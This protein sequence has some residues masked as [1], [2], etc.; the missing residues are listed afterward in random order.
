MNLIKKPWFLPIVLTILIV[1]IGNYY[2][3]QFI[4]QAETLPEDKVRTQLEGMYDGKV[5]RLS[6]KGSM[7]E[8][9]LVRNNGAYLAEVDAETGKVLSLIQTKENKV[10]ESIA[11]NEE[12]VGQPEATQQKPVAN[13]KEKHA[14]S[15]TPSKKETVLITEKEAVSIA[16]SQLNGEVDDVDFVKTTDGG[17]YLVEIEVE[18]DSRGDE[19]IYQIHAISGKILSVTWDD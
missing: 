19:A 3:K 6:L 16:L 8:A 17:Y 11:S 12:T 15:Q 10:D 18:D 9:E 1:F 13:K 2:T 14:E 7:Y 5:D 4:T